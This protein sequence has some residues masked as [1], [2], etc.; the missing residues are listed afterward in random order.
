MVKFEKKLP[1]LHCLHLCRV[2]DD[3]KY[4][5]SC[6]RYMLIPVRSVVTKCQRSGRPIMG[7][8]VPNLWDTIPSDLTTYKQFESI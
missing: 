3:V 6:H 8:S 5:I 1:S 7:V 2:S 4:K